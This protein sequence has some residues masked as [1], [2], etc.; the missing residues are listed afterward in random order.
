MPLGRNEGGKIDL[1]ALGLAD[2]DSS[3]APNLR[4]LAIVEAVA[5]A[6]VPVTPT[7]VN[8]AIGLPK[9]TLHRQGR[10]ACHQG[11]APGLLVENST[12]L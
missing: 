9:Q 7:Q 6:G 2:D 8:Q 4:P 10:P 12:W 1:G 11:H 5:R 3:I